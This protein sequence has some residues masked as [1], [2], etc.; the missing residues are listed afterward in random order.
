MIRNYLLLTQCA[1]D[2]GLLSTL[3]LVWGE[4]QHDL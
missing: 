1:S 4:T 3:T 2:G